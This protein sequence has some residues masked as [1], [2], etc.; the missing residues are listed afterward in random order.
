M[1]TDEPLSEPE[2]KQLYVSLLRGIAN[3]AQD[4]LCAVD[5]GHDWSRWTRYQLTR[6]LPIGPV[7]RKPEVMEE[8][9]RTRSER[10]CLN[11]GKVQHD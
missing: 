2:R 7:S 5:K 10:H 9:Y 1:T 8:T 3:E 4:R 11:C 6:D